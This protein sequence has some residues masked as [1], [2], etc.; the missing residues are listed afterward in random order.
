MLF[1]P[2]LVLVVLGFPSSIFERAFL[3]KDKRKKFVIGGTIFGCG[4]CI[5]EGQK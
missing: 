1:V 2:S 5:K 4:R 3:Y